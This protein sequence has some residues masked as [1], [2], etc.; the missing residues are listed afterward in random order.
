MIVK[1]KGTFIIIVNNQV[2]LA[3]FLRWGQ[4][5]HCNHWKRLQCFWEW[6]SSIRVYFLDRVTCSR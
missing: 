1:S 4:K 5:H 2:I 6:G 3:G